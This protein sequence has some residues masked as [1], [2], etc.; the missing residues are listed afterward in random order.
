MTEILAANHRLYLEETGLLAGRRF[1][2]PEPA[3]QLAF[4]NSSQPVGRAL[5]Y[6]T[7]A[8]AVLDSCFLAVQD[9]AASARK[10]FTNAA[11][12]TSLPCSKPAS[13]VK[14]DARY[15]RP[16]QQQPPPTHH[17]QMHPQQSSLIQAQRQSHLLPIHHWERCSSQHVLQKASGL[18]TT[19][20]DCKLNIHRHL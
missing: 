16:Q 15:H 6:Q 9:A 17:Q 14:L 7:Q 13:P 12:K 5:Q 8:E 4:C 2:S 18:Q 11:S 20:S 1:L 10:A 19:K 3:S